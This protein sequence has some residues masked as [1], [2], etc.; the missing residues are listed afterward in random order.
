[1]D[2]NKVQKA[3]RQIVEV[4]GN[5]DMAVLTAG[6]FA[7]GG[8]ADTGE[9]ELNKMYR[10]NFLTTYHIARQ[11][12]LQM[13]EQEDGGQVI[14]TGS[15]PAIHPGS[16]GDMLSYA[17]SK[18]LVFRLAEVINE[19]GKN[20]GITAS[21]IVPGTIDTPQNREAMPD[22]DFTGWVS[23]SEIADNVYH[24]STPAGKQLRESIIKVYG[25][26][27]T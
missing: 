13:E 3:V 22:A 25:E 24:L 17:F 19:D 9:E 5:I 14:F 27:Q 1:L 23:A 7:M 16:A 18:S 8:L 10:L 11:V 6:G 15:R 20:S 4:F 2:E 26:S 12:F 21:V